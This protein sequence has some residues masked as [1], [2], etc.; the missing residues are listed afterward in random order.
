MLALLPVNQAAHNILWFG[1]VPTLEV[2][3]QPDVSIAN[4]NAAAI[5]KAFNGRFTGYLAGCRS[6]SSLE[7]SC[8][9]V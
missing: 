8:V 5:K 7:C 3:N 6:V 2:G 4:Q 1:A 9:G